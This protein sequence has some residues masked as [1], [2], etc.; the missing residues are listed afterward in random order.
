MLTCSKGRNQ[1]VT[2]YELPTQ[3]KA[4]AFACTHGFLLSK[5]RLLKLTTGRGAWK[6]EFTGANMVTFSS[7]LF[8]ADACPKP[9]IPQ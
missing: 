1:R 8:N 4:Q 6:A 9:C 2:K 5:G 7:G 3:R